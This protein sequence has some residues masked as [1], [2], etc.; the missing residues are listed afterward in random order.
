MRNT[1][2]TLVAEEMFY[3]LAFPRAKQYKTIHNELTT[4]YLLPEQT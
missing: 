2:Q 1:I 3:S 4:T